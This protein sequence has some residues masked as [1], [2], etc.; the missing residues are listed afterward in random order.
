MPAYIINLLLDCIKPTVHT[1]LKG[2]HIIFD[3]AVEL[4]C[5]FIIRA[6]YYKKNRCI[7]QGLARA[8]ETY[9]LSCID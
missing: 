1:L 5:L 6:N 9:L 2:I 8:I 3:E 7:N 4:E